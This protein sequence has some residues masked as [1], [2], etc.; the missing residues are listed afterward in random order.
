MYYSVPFMFVHKLSSILFFVEAKTGL[1]QAEPFI[2][3][4]GPA[5]KSLS[6]PTRSPFK[7]HKNEKFFGSDFEFF[8]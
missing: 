2:P 7:E 5:G 1:A 3:N 6:S 4:K 8:D